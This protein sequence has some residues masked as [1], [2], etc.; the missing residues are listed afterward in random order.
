MEEISVQEAIKRS[1]QTEKNAML[2]YRFGAEQ[3]KNPQ[4]KQTFELL[5]REE[6]DHARTFFDLY[7]G[8]DLSDFDALM[9]EGA[10]DYGQW[11]TDQEKELIAS[12]DDRRAMEMALEKEKSLAE[13]LRKMAALFTDPK[14]KAVFLQNVESTDGHYQLIEAE[15]ARLMG[16]VHDSD[17]DTFVRE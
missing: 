11:L 12:F 6:R 17:M 16:M 9:A 1:I 3:M 2:F 15:F 8:D 5:A 4:A 13:H 10:D 14:V 7:E